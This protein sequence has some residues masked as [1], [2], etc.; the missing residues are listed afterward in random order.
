MLGDEGLRKVQRVVDALDRRRGG[1][2]TVSMLGVT[3]QRAGQPRAPPRRADHRP[4]AS[5]RGR[6]APTKSPLVARDRRATYVAAYLRSGARPEARPASASRRSS[7]GIDGVTV[8][9][10]AVAVPQVSDQVSEDLARAETLAFP[11]LF[12]LSLIV[13]RGA[14][15]ALL[16]LFVGLLTIM[17]TFLG[18]R[19]VN[20]GCCCRS[21]R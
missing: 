15:A 3:E 14:V 16:P 17:G 2:R 13:F 1:A 12:L 21:S 4:G 18:L 8:G 11:L 5:G 9:G 10:Y 20:E 6:P 7:P 19:I